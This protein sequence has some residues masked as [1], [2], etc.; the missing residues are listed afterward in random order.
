MIRLERRLIDTLNRLRCKVHERGCAQFK[1]SLTNT[2]FQK[3]TIISGISVFSLLESGSQAWEWN[4]LLKSLQY[5]CF[6]RKKLIDDLLDQCMY[7]YKRFSKHSEN[8]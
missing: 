5:V 4:V 7:I 6:A 2:P 8:F 1:A 3:G